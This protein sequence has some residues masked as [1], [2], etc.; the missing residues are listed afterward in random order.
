ME[1]SENTDLTG[2]EIFQYNGFLSAR[3]LVFQIK[4]IQKVGSF[5]VESTGLVTKGK[6]FSW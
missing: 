3:A 1:N 2:T 4:V 5:V 6:K